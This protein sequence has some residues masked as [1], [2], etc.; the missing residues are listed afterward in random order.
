MGIASWRKPQAKTLA[1]KIIARVVSSI[2]PCF[3]QKFPYLFLYCHR[4]L[5]SSVIVILSQSWFR[6]WPEFPIA[7]HGVVYVHKSDFDSAIRD[8]NKTIELEPDYSRIYYN[9]GVAFQKKNEIACAIEDYNKEI[10]LNP[11]NT[12]AYYKRGTAWLELKEWEKAKTDL[13]VAMKKGFE[14]GFQFRFDY[15]GIPGFEEKYGKLPE[16]IAAMLTPPQA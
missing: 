8:Y 10:E 11:D 1:I 15:Q 3:F 4:I 7:V 13:T 9:R 14:I 16:D 12:P 6:Q 2:L 5:L